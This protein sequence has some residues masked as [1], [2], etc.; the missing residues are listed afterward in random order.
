MVNPNDFIAAARAA[1]NKNVS[2]MNTEATYKTDY[3]EIGKQAVT[4]A[5][6]NSANTAKN[7][8]SAARQRIA[9]ETDVAI[10][11]EAAKRDKDIRGIKNQARMTGL[12]AGGVALTAGGIALMNEEDEPNEQL[13]VLQ[14]QRDFWKNQYDKAGGDI[15]AAGERLDELSKQLNNSNGNSS[16]V[17]SSSSSSTNS[18]TSQLS[19]TNT[20][21]KPKGGNKTGLRLVNDLVGKGY[22]PVT[23]AAVAGNAQYESDNF[24]AYEEYS[25]NSYGTRG[26]GFLQWTNAGGA[27]RRDAFES[28]AKSNN[29]DPASYEASAGYIDAEMRGGSNWTGGQTLDGFKSITDLNE[30]TT[31]YMNTYLRPAKDTANLS[32]RQNNA[33]AL[34][35]AYRD[36]LK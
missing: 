8:A 24:R 16:G 12:L 1:M 28:W 5:A 19:G 10:T 21:S 30:A 31:N 2:L 7:N 22:S 34:L 4:E 29:L 14:K 33:S 18:S 9:S 20:G 6:R 15:T 3:D 13:E 11:K 27:N 17:D 23:A 32:A 35:Q 26:A 25:P 36:S